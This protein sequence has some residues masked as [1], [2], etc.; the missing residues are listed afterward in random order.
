MT[1]N[2]LC[3]NSSMRQEGSRSRALASAVVKQLSQLHQDAAVVERDLS[4]GVQFIN[5]NWIEANF[6]APDAR[7]P[8]QK[9]ELEYSDVLFNELLAADFLVIAAPIYNF[10]IPA[11]LKA[12]VDMVVRAKQAF[13]YA[14]DGPK[15][16]LHG[17]KAYLVVTSGGTKAGSEVDYASPYLK[18]ILGFVGITDVVLIDSDL[19]GVDAATADE[20]AL[21][22]IARLD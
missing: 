15:G 12:W 7:T 13:T 21:L 22:K 3:V 14:E 1:K 11:A 2:I 20:D 18:H 6:T 19:A 8:R 9:A 10:G 17:K 16:L 5:A 4:D